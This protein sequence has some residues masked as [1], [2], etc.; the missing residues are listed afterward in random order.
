MPY[1]FPVNKYGIVVPKFELWING[2]EL[3]EEQYNLVEEIVYESYDTGSDLA[4][5]TFNDP[6]LILINDKTFIK[7]SK[8]YLG[9]GWK[10]D[11]VTWMD[12]Y[13]SLVDIN[14][15]E[16]GYPILSVTCMDESYLLNRLNV[17]ATYGDITFSALANIVAVRHKMKV[18]GKPTKT[19]H[20][21]VSQADET[22]IT[23]LTRIADKEDLKVKVKNGVIIWEDKFSAI[24]VQDDFYWKESP[25]NLKSFTPRI[26][27][28]DKK[29][30]INKSDVT[31]NKT[32]DSGTADNT[33]GRNQLGSEPTSQDYYIYTKGANNWQ[34][35]EK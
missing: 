6:N 33:T 30:A 34:K 21:S 5:I 17:K 4:T 23:L 14:F 11:I 16:Q 24:E 18:Q 2:K 15:P 25:Y 1:N 10:S 27:I 8:V 32:V 13:I 19:I 7:G 9:G 3:T 12:G 29:D 20:E 35:V 31:D 26:V 22:D 28:A